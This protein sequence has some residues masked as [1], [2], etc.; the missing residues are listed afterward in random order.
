MAVNFQR[1]IQA[2]NVIDAE[3]YN[4]IA[5]A[6]NKTYHDDWANNLTSADEIRLLDSHIRYDSRILSL[7]NG[8]GSQSTYTFSIIDKNNNKVN[9]NIN[10]GDFIVVFLDDEFLEKNGNYSLNYNDNSISF[11]S[12]LSTTSKIE[13]YN[14][15][16][17]SIGWGQLNRSILIDTDEN[18]RPTVSANSSTSNSYIRSNTNGI[19]DKVNIMLERTKPDFTNIEDIIL[20]NGDPVKIISD[21]KHYLENDDKITLSE[22]IGTTELNDNF[23][24]ITK[25]MKDIQKFLI[26]KQFVISDY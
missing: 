11:F 26:D 20:T 16:L 5:R 8:M 14:R 18:F 25:S 24:N 6:I 1:N 3:D 21:G 23:Y 19:I 7:P 22:I 9:A 13:V 15:S 2:G 10:D 17:E 12:H 4:E